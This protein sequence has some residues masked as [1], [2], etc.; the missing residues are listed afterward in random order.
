MKKAKYYTPVVTIFDEKGKPDIAGNKAVWNHLIQGG[1][2]GLVIM[3]SIGEFFLLTTE[4]KVLIIDAATSFAG[5][6][7]PLYI[8]TGGMNEEETIYLSKYALSKGADAVMVVG[9]Y[10]FPLPQSAVEH[11]YD[12]VCNEVPGNVYLYSF[13]DRTGYDISPDTTL[14][15]LRKHKNIIGYKD[16]VG[17]MGHTRELIVKTVQEFP[18]FEVLSG[19]DE[20]M[21]HNVLSGGGGCIGGLSNIYPEL[22]AAWVHAVDEGDFYLC[23][24]IQKIFDR[25]MDIYAVA[26][27]FIPVI[28]E[29]VKNRGISICSR[30]KEPLQS[31]SKKQK[32]VLSCIMGS[33]EKEMM[34]IGVIL[35]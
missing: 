3:G 12:T 31:L 18:D 24:K 23:K 4:E 17:E 7:I 16:T 34:G 2:S 19:F 10:Y 11:Y 8:G 20:Y 25:L 9:P 1:V 35:Q 6:K 27:I 21:F 13:P 15:L 14:N 26:D 28:K 30:C 29:G 5:G 33:A 32:E 22:A